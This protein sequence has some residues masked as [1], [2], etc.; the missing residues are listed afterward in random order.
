MRF[1]AIPLLLLLAACSGGGSDAYTI[2]ASGPWQLS[3]GK[4]ARLGIALALKEINDAGGINGH[5]LVIKEVDDEADGRKAAQIA[6]Q[7][8]SDASISAVVGHVTSGA[9]V[10]AAKVYNGHLAALAT[11]ASSPDLTGISPWAFRV[12][13][14]DS[15]NAEA[16]A[17]FASES[18]HAR[19]AILY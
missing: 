15:A 6:Q 9:M 5:K 18:G 19:V 4:N 11:S 13:S 14:S 17:K 1:R 3:N 12:I 2:G 8:V 10:A 16:M 7:F